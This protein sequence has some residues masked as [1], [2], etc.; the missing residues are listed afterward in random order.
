[1]IKSI[2]KGDNSIVNCVQPHPNYC[3][4]ATSGIDN[5][6]R[7]WGPQSEE[8]AFEARNRNDHIDG[9]VLANQQR[10]LTTP[11]G[12]MTAICRSS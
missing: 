11:I 7:L 2:Y 4:L 10:F 9:V 6:I 5:E 12:D 3:L 8:P 1:M